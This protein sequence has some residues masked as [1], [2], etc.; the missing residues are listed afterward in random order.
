MS[1]TEEERASRARNLAYTQGRRDADVDAHL[2]SHEKRLNA[3]NGSIE[4]HA[5]NAE[6]LKNSITELGEKVDAVA[7][8]LVT[9]K[10]IEADRVQQIKDANEQQIST[11]QFWLGV[12][13]ICVM[14]TLGVMTLIVRAHGG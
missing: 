7:A 8:T 11:K 1:E 5:R 3:I 14:I 4:K 2:R 9:Q 10:A 12:A 13:T 6:A